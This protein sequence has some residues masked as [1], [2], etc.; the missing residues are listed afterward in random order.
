MYKACQTR[1]SASSKREVTKADRVRPYTPKPN[2]I[3]SHNRNSFQLEHNVSDI[4]RI[5]VKTIP[6]K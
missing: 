3:V 2:A 1:L 4:G 5:A 6:K